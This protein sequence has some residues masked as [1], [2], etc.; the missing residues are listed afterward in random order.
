MPL[1]DFRRERTNTS[2][3]NLLAAH[4]LLTYG[5]EVHRF[6]DDLPVS[7]DRFQVDGCEKRPCIL[8]AFQLSKQHPVE[9]K[10]TQRHR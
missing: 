5:G 7:R 3:G 6:L 9:C 10:N 1:K 8:M 4:K 2:D